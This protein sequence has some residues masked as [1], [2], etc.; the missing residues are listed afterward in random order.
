M[1]L[2]PREKLWNELSLEEKIEDL[3]YDVAKLFTIDEEFGHKNHI[4]VDAIGLVHARL[5]DLSQSIEK[6]DKKVT[7]FRMADY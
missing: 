6:L 2:N 3:R 7:A 4:F 1:P 5:D